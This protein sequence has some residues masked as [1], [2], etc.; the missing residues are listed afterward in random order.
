MFTT[1]QFFLIVF[2]EI[3]QYAS[4]CENYEQNNMRDKLV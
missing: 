4:T 2:I 1:P 3:G